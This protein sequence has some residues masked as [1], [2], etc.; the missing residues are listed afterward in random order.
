M[1]AH[2]VKSFEAIFFDMD[3]TL[4]DTEPYWLASETE[5][6]A[7]FDYSWSLDDQKSCLGGP[8]SR[9][10]QYMFDRAKANS[11]Q[12]FVEELIELVA[13]NFA[14]EIN[15][16]PGARELLEEIRLEDIPCALVSAS[17]RRL[18]NS[19]LGHLGEGYFALSISSDDVEKSKPDPDP[20]LTAA[21][22]LGVDIE[23]CLILEDSKT[24]IASGQASGAWVLAIPHIVTIEPDSRTVIVDSLV[25]FNLSKVFSLFN[26][27]I[28]NE[29]KQ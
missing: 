20:Y 26:D 21:R 27:R 25:E 6:M 29:L 3:G 14:L 8:L 13:A 23:N 1:K 7:R 15:F 24:G 12:F 18:V 2:D 28:S 11:P 17:P 16:M 19:A 5:L 10:G 4:V 9:V 22:Q